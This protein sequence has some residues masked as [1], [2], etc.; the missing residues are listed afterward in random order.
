M[1]TGEAFE[2]RAKMA[3]GYS[4]KEVEGAEARIDKRVLALISLIETQY[5]AV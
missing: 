1:S 4:G 2:L 3:A 5:L